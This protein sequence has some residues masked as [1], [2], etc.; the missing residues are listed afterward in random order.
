ME[1]LLSSADAA[2]YQVKQGRKGGYLFYRD[3]KKG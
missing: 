2:M 1:A 3:L